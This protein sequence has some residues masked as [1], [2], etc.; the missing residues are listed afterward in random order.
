MTS[1]RLSLIPT[2]QD[3]CE[4]EVWVL[5]CYVA[6]VVLVVGLEYFLPLAEFIDGYVVKECSGFEDGHVFLPVRLLWFPTLV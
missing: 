2:S 4:V 5:V 6:L 1:D 3:E